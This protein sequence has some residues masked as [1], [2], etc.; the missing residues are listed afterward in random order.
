MTAPTTKGIEMH[1]P[2][3]DPPVRAA[4]V[5][6]VLSLLA[7]VA[8]AVAAP[9]MAAAAQ[10]RCTSLTYIPVWAGQPAEMHVPTIGSQTGNKECHLWF[11]TTGIAVRVLQEA[12]VSCYQQQIDVD[13]DYGTETQ[14]AVRNVQRE[15]LRWWPWAAQSP[16]NVRV[17][18]TYGPK[19]RAFM[20]FAI[21]APG[22]GPM[23]SGCYY[24]G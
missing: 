18:G 20:R 7:A 3:L 24:P 17:D 23:L 22:G 21:F 15:I 10:P 19:T 14:E 16:Y 12:M 6:V 1:M 11:G 13:G 2:R 9:G 4:A 8:L 5:T